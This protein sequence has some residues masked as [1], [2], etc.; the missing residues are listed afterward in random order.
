M[1]DEEYFNFTVG[2]D[3]YKIYA[4]VP[5]VFNAVVSSLHNDEH[6]ER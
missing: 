6:G 3:S 4:S 5:G 2:N 1:K